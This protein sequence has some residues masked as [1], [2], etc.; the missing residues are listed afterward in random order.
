DA[1][2]Q[3]LQQITEDAI[4]PGDRARLSDAASAYIA[5]LHLPLTLLAS[6]R[7]DLQSVTPAQVQRVVDL[8]DTFFADLVATQVKADSQASQA[9]LWATIGTWVTVLATSGG[10]TF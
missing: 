4:D 1:V 3:D 9:G 10:L 5:Q 6:N 7:L 2:A 8:R